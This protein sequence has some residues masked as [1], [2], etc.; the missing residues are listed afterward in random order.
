MGLVHGHV[1][2]FLRD[3][4]KHPNVELV[5][6]SEPDAA[7]RQ[8]FQQSTRLPESTFFATEKEMLQKTKPQAIV[9]YTAPAD[10]LGAISIAAP[11]HVA[12]MVEKPLATTV[13]DAEA[14]AK[15]S[16][17]YDVPV[18]TNYATTWF[19]ANTAVYDTVKQGKVGT[20][21]KIVAYDG[22]RGPKE[23]GVS[24]EI[25]NW[26][27]DPLKNGGGAI[28]D[29]GCY[30]LDLATWLM[31]GEMPESVTAITQQLKPE[32]YTRVDDDATIILKYAHVQAVIMA[33]W[34]W[35]IDRRDLAVY[36]SNGVVSAI[37]ADGFR[38]Q[39]INEKQDTVN[40]APSLTAPQDNSLDYLT[41]VLTHKF[42][43]KG[44]PTALDT[45]VKV[46]RLLAAARESAG[47]GKTVM[48]NP[49][50]H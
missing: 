45:N 41:A 6:I 25:F 19:P 43:P 40:P 50:K 47:S 27:T 35:P 28:V 26:I 1:A 2:G 30:G 44:D 49:L 18:L 21:R 16:A 9:V 34:N 5:G 13:P 12:A 42:T 10:H 31:N 8:K 36:G 4:P 38:M 7:L 17:Q 3:L 39:L 20:V 33:S 23:I 37:R 11:M 24:T 14:I 32:I 48:L 22:H 15:L 46:V 29:F